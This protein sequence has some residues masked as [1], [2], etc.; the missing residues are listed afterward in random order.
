ML[1]FSPVLHD[2]NFWLVFLVDDSLPVLICLW[3]SRNLIFL[4]YLLGAKVFILSDNRNLD[5]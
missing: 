2:R 4:L 5:I 3:Y 1:S